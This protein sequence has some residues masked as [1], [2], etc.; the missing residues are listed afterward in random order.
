MPCRGACGDALLKT[1]CRL[2]MRAEW[3]VEL[4]VLHA[5]RRRLET[6]VLQL[7]HGSAGAR[8]TKKQF[9]SI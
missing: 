7:R 8:L 6:T 4:S 3:L 1:L 9:L 5:T 2:Q